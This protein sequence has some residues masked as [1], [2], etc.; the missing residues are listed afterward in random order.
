MASYTINMDVKNHSRPS[1]LNAMFGTTRPWEESWR[2][3]FVLF[4]GKPFLIARTPI[5]CFPK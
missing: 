4:G 1:S 2:A 3:T 5:S